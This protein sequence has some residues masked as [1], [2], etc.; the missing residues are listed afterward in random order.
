MAKVMLEGNLTIITPNGYGENLEK[1][2][3]K[4]L[5]PRGW[6]KETHK[7]KICWTKLP[8]HFVYIP[9]YVPHRCFIYELD[10][11]IMPSISLDFIQPILNSI[12]NKQK[13]L[14]DLDQHLKEELEKMQEGK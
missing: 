8:Y 7:H 11:L 14:N 3:D 13:V 10:K 9:K 2:L 12:D 6:Q 1:E 4:L 5:L